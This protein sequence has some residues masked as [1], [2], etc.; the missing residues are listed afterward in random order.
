M[1]SEET[2]PGNGHPKLFNILYKPHDSH[3]IENA[4]SA[5]CFSAKEKDRISPSFR[6]GEAY[7]DTGQGGQNHGFNHFGDGCYQSAACL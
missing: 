5:A 7:S 2:R 1:S 3:V 6:H 4:R